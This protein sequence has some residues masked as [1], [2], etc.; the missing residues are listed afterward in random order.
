MV[1][2]VGGRWVAGVFLFLGTGVVYFCV[3]PSTQSWMG[4]SQ[5]CHCI[6]GFVLRGIKQK[7]NRNASG[8]IE[9]KKPP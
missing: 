6:M 8:W 2:W 9:I 5:T 1:F 7:E 3:T 4:T